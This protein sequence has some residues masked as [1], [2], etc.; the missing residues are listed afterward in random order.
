[1]IN[2]LVYFGGVL[3]VLLSGGGTA[4]WRLSS[5]F[6]TEELKLR[7]QQETLAKTNR[8]LESRLTKAELPNDNHPEVVSLQGKIHHLEK[9][10]AVAQQDITIKDEENSRLTH[11]ASQLEQQVVNLRSQFSQLEKFHEQLKLDHQKQLQDLLKGK[12]SLSL[13]LRT[14]VS[15]VADLRSQ[16]LALEKAQKN[17]DSALLKLQELEEA[18]QLWSSEKSSLEKDWRSQVEGLELALSQEKVSNE[19]INQQL[20]QAQQQG[21]DYQTQAEQAKATLTEI[22]ARLQQL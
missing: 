21:Q 10:L 14:E 7:E 5:R 12:E 19:D 13:N 18:Q 20:I 6:R 9:D 16:I 1:M 22:Q 2:E 17:Q 3:L 15:L 8:E 11:E 4:F